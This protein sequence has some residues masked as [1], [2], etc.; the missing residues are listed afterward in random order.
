M[1]VLTIFF[2]TS[3]QIWAWH[4]HVTNYM[5]MTYC[6]FDTVLNFIESHIG[7]SLLSRVVLEQ[8]EEVCLGGPFLP[9]HVD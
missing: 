8:L 4:S 9:P 5:T 7:S 1:H 6:L 2:E 3:L